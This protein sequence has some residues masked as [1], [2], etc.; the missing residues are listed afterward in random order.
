MDNQRA[1]VNRGRRRGT[2]PQ[3]QRSDGKAAPDRV[4]QIPNIPLPP[5]GT[6]AGTEA[7]ERLRSPL[8]EQGHGPIVLRRLAV[9]ARLRDAAACSRRYAPTRSQ[10]GDGQT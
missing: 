3:E 10:A 7:S 1:E 4:E 6:P 8:R 5:N 2:L 9:R